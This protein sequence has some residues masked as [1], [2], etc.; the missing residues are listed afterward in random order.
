MDK[1]RGDEI[2]HCLNKEE[3]RTDR[4]KTC[5]TF[6]ALRDVLEADKLDL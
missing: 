5:Y 3:K 1:Q 2:G 6:P 4:K